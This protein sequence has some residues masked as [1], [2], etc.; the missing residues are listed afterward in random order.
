[1][2]YCTFIYLLICLLCRPDLLR[3][4]GISSVEAFPV[5]SPLSGSPRVSTPPGKARYR[6]KPRHRRTNSKGSH[7]FS[8]VLK[9]NV[10]IAEEQQPLQP[11]QY[12]HNPHSHHYPHQL[13]PE[14]PLLPLQKRDNTAALCA[15]ELRYFGPAAA[16]R[17][18]HT[19]HLQRSSPDL[20]NTTLEADARQQVAIGTAALCPCC[21]GHPLPGCLRCQD[22][23]PD[24][25]LVSTRD[26]DAMEEKQQPERGSSPQNSL[27]R[28]LRTLSKVSQHEYMR[29]GIQYMTKYSWTLE[30]H[31]HMSLSFHI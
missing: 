12:H 25:S 6:S 24:C 21:Q 22:M 4:D 13:P 7:E 11:Q 16:L 9:P 26:G 8:G 20:I 18:P 10:N 29:S 17:S 27:P 3:S 28:T 2:R 23:L 19:E 31:I 5:S 15:S 1:M 30:H 14:S